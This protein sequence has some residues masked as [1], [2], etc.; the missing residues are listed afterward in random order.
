MFVS[1]R[2]APTGLLVAALAAAGSAAPVPA[3][4]VKAEK[5]RVALE[6]KLHGL[7]GAGPCEGQLTFRPDGTYDWKF[8]G[9]DGVTDSGT[10]MVR[11]D[12]AAP[13]LVLA[14][15]KSDESD[16]AG[17]TVE[18]KLA[19]GETGFGI[20]PAEGKPYVFTRLMKGPRP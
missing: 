9:P 5:E 19:L 12:P 10:W 3:D 20:Q 7:W 16:R 8:R 17:K 4:R 11:P 18:L 13:A 2:V 1:A 15:Q 14:C 6:A